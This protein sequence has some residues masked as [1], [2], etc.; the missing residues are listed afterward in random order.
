[1]TSFQVFV[2]GQIW[3]INRERN[4]HHMRR[5]EMVAELRKSARIL[6]LQ[7]MRKHGGKR[8]SFPGPVTVEFLPFQLPGVLADTANHLP[9]CKA[10]L[11]GLVDAGLIADDTP[12]F[13]VS[14]TFYPPVK[15]KIVGISVLVK[16]V[17]TPS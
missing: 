5:A 4:L 9:P 6:T 10:V 11:D 17:V 14:Q 12:E 1:M 16:D 13:V 2:P 8:W 3:T 7:Q 15:S